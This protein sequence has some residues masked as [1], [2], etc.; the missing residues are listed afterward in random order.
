VTRPPGGEA[1][2]PSPF[3]LRSLATPP[4][5]MTS[6]S[7]SSFGDGSQGFPNRRT[8]PRDDGTALALQGLFLVIITPISSHMEAP[9]SA[10]LPRKW[11]KPNAKV[12]DML[13]NG[14]VP[15]GSRPY[16]V[17]NENGGESVEAHVG[18]QGDSSPLLVWKISACASPGIGACS[19]F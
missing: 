2:V 14:V 9:T 10:H 16:H 15:A 18:Q 19:V 8:D 3:P 11:E 1:S 12:T 7:L 6:E 5:M 13:A 4:A 17:V